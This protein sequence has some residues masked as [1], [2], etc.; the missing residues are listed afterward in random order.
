MELSEAT[1]W[2][3]ER[4]LGVLITIRAEGRLVARFTPTSVSGQI[5]R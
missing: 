4:K 5:H 1:S 3:A 2:A